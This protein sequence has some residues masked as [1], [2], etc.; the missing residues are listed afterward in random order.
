MTEL[1]YP[2]LIGISS[3]ALAQILAMLGATAN[4][5][6]WTVILFSLTVVAIPVVLSGRPDIMESILAYAAIAVGTSQTLFTALK[7]VGLINITTS[8]KHVAEEQ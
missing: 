7:Q 3:T 5:K 6:R 8:G 2:V 1:T 4:I